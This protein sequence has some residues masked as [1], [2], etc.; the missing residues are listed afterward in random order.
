M[1]VQTL[2]D[3]LER[4]RSATRMRTLYFLGYGGFD[5]AAAEP[6][7]AIDAEQALQAKRLKG[8]EHTRVAQ[9]YDAA[10]AQMGLRFSDLP[11]LACDCSGFVAWALGLSRNSAPLLGGQPIYTGTM[12]A[13]AT[14]GQKMFVRLARAVP[15]A[16]MIHPKPT[17]QE[18][19]PGHVAIVTQVNERG[20]ATKIIHCA[21]ENYR[22]TRMAGGVDTAI[23]ETGI[24]AF[25]PHLS[26]TI[27][28]MVRPFLAPL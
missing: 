16:L 14:H 12:H 15:G 17:P 1:S 6:G 5:G 23:A 20:E 21:P 24:D 26:I 9:E 8:G 28:A 10:M 7:S 4:A 27:Y 25:L 2:Q 3:F 22:L 11:R 18:V 19:P 13:D